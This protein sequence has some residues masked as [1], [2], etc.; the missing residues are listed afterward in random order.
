VNETTADQE[1]LLHPVTLAEC[2]VAPA[3]V[4][5]LDDAANKL[6]AAYEVIDID[7]DAP[8]RW[9]RLRAHAGLRLPD[10]IVLDAAITHGASGILTFD[11]NLAAAA[12]K[13]N[14]AI[15]RLGA[16]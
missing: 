7:I 10:A 3:K 9:A 13:R 5:D 2:L 14:I 16:A 8:E 1:I 6:R 15:N 12:T 4:G 11:D